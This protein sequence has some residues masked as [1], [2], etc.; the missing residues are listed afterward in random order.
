[1]ASTIVKLTMAIFESAQIARQEND[2]LRELLRRQGL[3]DAK[4]QRGVA[5]YLKKS[6]DRDTADQLMRK[7]CE[8]ILARLPEIDLEEALEGMKIRGKPQ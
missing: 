5:A 7:A 2:A 1:M 8:E 3:S 6:R 4:I